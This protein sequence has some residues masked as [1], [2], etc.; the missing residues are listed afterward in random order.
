LI[1]ALFLLLLVFLNHLFLLILPL[2]GTISLILQFFLKSTDLLIKT[3]NHKLKLEGYRYQFLGLLLSDNLELVSRASQLVYLVKQLLYLDRKLLNGHM[4]TDG[5]FGRWGLLQLG[6][7]LQD[8]L[9]CL[10]QVL[11]GLVV[12]APEL[13]ELDG[14]LR[15]LQVVRGGVNGLG[16]WL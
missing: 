9:L 8:V 16:D 7:E 12:L 6:L 4:E 2:F 3:I 13:L 15:D 5:V 1:P 10:L 11:L 14:E